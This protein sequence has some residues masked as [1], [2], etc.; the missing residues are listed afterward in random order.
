MR[1]STDSSSSLIVAP[2]GSS[3]TI[4]AAEVIA[5]Y[6]RR[7]RP[8]VV[9]AHRK[10]I[11]DQ[12]SKKLYRAKIRHGIVKA[13]YSP[14]P[15]ES[16]QVAS[17]QTLWV[18]AMRSQ[19][20]TLPPA[21]LL[22]IDE[23]HHATARTWR[24]LIEAYPDAVL[25]GLT[26]TPCRGDGCGLGGIFTCMIEAPQVPD[27][28]EGGFLVRSRVYAPVRPNLRGVHVRHGDYVENEL[29]AR[30]D[31]PKLVGDIVTHWHKFAERRKTVAFA[32]NVAHSLHL[33]NEFVRAGVRAEH[34]DGGTPDDDRDAIL[35]LTASSDSSRTAVR[36]APITIPRP[37]AA[38]TRC[39]PSSPR[40]GATSPVGS[41][42]STKPSSATTRP[43]AAPLSRFHQRLKSKAGCDR[44]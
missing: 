36:T 13:G 21:D 27:L 40:R 6:M 7:Y 10:E 5:D 42:T 30:M 43:G 34:L 28:I 41:L 12:T 1:P 32:V 33:Q 15:M 44:A 17:V 39:S 26:A 4:V 2:T 9:L 38:G 24:K 8:V 23:C 3:K 14:R 37:A 20:M 25:I 11:I 16:V 22:I 19:A 18:R 35:A 29:A 31:N